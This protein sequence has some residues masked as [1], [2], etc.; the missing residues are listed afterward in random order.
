MISAR[1]SVV[2]HAVGLALSGNGE[3]TL[4]LSFLA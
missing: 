3:K 4:G 2:L 1:D